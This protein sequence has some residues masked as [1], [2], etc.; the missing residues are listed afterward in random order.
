MLHHHCEMLGSVHHNA[1]VGRFQVIFGQLRAIRAGVMERNLANGE[2]PGGKGGEWTG[3]P[4][5]G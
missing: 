1:K 5:Y 2:G 4:M 3:S